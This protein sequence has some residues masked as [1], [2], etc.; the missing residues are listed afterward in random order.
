MKK[1]GIITFHDTLNYGASLQCF[2]LQKKIKDMGGSA[3]VIDYKCNQFLKEYSPFFVSEKNIRKFLYMLASLKMNL[4]KV[5]KK[6]VFQKT[7]LTLSKPYTSENIKKS[8]QEYD[9]FITGSDQVW[10]FHYAGFDKAYYL[11]FVEANKKKYSYGASFGMTDIP[12]EKEREYQKLLKGYNGISV[13]ELSGKYLVEKI[14][15]EEATVVVDPVLLLSADEWVRIAKKPKYKNYVLA[16][17]INDTAAYKIAKRISD[18]TGYKI[19]YLSA[20]IKCFN[21]S[22]KV[23]DIG[24]E[25]FLGWFLMADY[26]VTDSFHGTVFSILFRKKFWVATNLGKGKASNRIEEL[27]KECNLEKQIVRKEIMTNIAQEDIDF[28]SAQKILNNAIQKSEKFLEQIM[29]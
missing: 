18:E 6:K 17:S 7:Y 21:K 27:L 2:A 19:V 29:G 9:I 1:I 3:E 10:N 5:Y 13:R 25:D 8:N 4:I 11:D 14:L 16:Y 24:P 28:A 26:V 20:P 15:D 22:K 23:R 12:S